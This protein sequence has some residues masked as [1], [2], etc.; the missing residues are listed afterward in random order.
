MPARRTSRR[1]RLLY[2]LVVI[3][4]ALALD[5]AVGS[6]MNSEDG[7]RRIARGEKVSDAAAETI[8]PF[9]GW[10]M[11][12]QVAVASDHFGKMVPVNQLGFRDS[13]EGVYQRSD[14]V[15]VLGIAGGSVAF[16]VAIQGAE[17][18]KRDLEALPGLQGKR[19]QI[20]TLAASGY[21][22]PQ[23]L[24]TL[25]YFYALGAEFD[26]VINIDGYN[27]FALGIC[28]NVR[29]GTALAYPRAWHARSVLLEDPKTSIPAFELLRLR[30]HRQSM[31][32]RLE[33]SIFRNS[34]VCNSLWKYRD[35]RAKDELNDLGRRLLSAKKTSFVNHGPKPDYP[36]DDAA[37]AAAVELWRSCSVQMRHLC[38]G[39]DTLYLHVLQPNQHFSG[40]KTLSEFETKN[41]FAPREALGKVVDRAYPLAV[42][43]SSGLAADDVHFLDATMVF[44]DVSESVYR[45]PFCHYNEFGNELLTRLITSK[46]S[47]MLSEPNTKQP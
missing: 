14:D 1:R 35:T 8:H 32:R 15:F 46:L 36:D 11:N 27:E 43:A 2:V 18:L 6:G 42:T 45:D 39:N 37:I 22:Q 47:V 13:S 5:F 4:M 3:A 44:K 25:A 23:Q 34:A 24:H 31:A 17:I 16:Q 33:N 10:V 40:S 28:E 41:C 7:R 20:V 26:A 29:G 38:A 12:P 9:L 21:K 30:A 19:V